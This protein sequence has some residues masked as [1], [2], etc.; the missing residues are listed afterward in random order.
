MKT[1][2]LWGKMDGQTENW[3]AKKIKP[4]SEWPANAGSSEKGSKRNISDLRQTIEYGT[5]RLLYD[6]NK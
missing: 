3:T 4:Q 2:G 5:F 6:L 1:D